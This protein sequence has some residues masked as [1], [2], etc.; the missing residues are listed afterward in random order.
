VKTLAPRETSWRELAVVALG[1]A[2]VTR[3]F[4]FLTDG[5]ALFTRPLWTDELHTT[6][7]AGRATPWAIISDLANGADYGPPLL[8]FGAWML[9]VAAG[10]LSPIL[11]RVTSLLCVWGALLLVYAVLRRHFER[12]ASVAGIVAVASH[13]LVVAHSFEGRF[14]GPWL[15]CAAFFAWSLSLPA[16]RRRSI[17]LAIAAVCLA[18][19][20]WYGIVSLGIMVAAAVLSYGRRWR[21]GLRAVA[22][23]AAGLAALVACLP[24]VMG[25]RHALT[26]NTWV[27]EF[28]LA[29]LDSLSRIYW[30]AMLPVLAAVLFIARALYAARR[31]NEEVVAGAFVAPLRD[32]GV[33]ALMA[34]ALM[35]LAL[36]AM[37]LLGQPSMWP[38]YALPAV[39]AWAPFVAL[40]LESLGRWA[41]RAFI[42]IAVVVWF[43]NFTREA[44]Y[45]RNFAVG[46]QRQQLAL[47]QAASLRVPVVFQSMHAMYSAASADWNHRTETSFLELPDSTME[48]V[49]PRGGRFDAL[50]KALRVERDVA[51]VHS[52]RFGFPRLTSQASLDTT[53]RF[54]L[55]ASDE[56]LP[57]GYSGVEGIAVA[58]FPHHRLARLGPGLL[59][60]DR[61]GAATP[62]AAVNG[63]QR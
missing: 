17:T 47:A 50:N 61:T 19:I 11:L 48:A 44:Q 1:L 7:L 38:R 16:G 13:S 32:P 56:N 31:N 5:G 40:V 54:V 2:I 8:H 34:L 14:Y 45:K 20:H 25:Q 55:V 52:R 59:L 28:S 33:V 21:E 49:F 18:T 62:A 36:A 35:P 53:S 39:L 51:R 3:A 43:T 63:R 37:S 22:P 15:L 42:A 58:V 57:P 12:A 23:A 10:S 29:Q 27:P 46:V 30:T 6:L 26:V 24:L 4:L 41:T 9:R 60:F